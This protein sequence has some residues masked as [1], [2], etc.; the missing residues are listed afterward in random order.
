MAGAAV[1]EVAATIR[2]LVNRQ[3]RLTARTALEAV[4]ERQSIKES[5]DRYRV[6]GKQWRR[7]IPA[8]RAISDALFDRTK[9]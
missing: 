8:S 1:L 9:H 2:L 4:L 3:A 7:Q 6:E 5:F